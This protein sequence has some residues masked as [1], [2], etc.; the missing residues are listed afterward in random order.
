VA[1]STIERT[2][3]D[4]MHDPKLGVR[5]EAFVDLR[6]RA[7]RVFRVHD[8]GKLVPYEG[9][10]IIYSA[11][12]TSPMSMKEWLGAPSR[13]RAVLLQG[14]H[15]RRRRRRQRRAGRT[16]KV[17]SEQASCRHRREVQVHLRAR[18]GRVREVAA[19]AG[20]VDDVLGRHPGM[21]ARGGADGRRGGAPVA[22]KLTRVD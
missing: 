3:M 9:D 13:E 14:H 8:D 20:G 18:A 21:G 11:D 17:R 5:P 1:Q 7:G 15:G 22:M 16:F 12:A 4:A 19:E 6:E 2:L 10:T